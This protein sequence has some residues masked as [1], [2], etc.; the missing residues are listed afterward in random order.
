MKVILKKDIGGLGRKYEIK[1]VSDGYAVNYLVPNKLAE[2]ASKEAVKRAQIAKAATEEELKVQENLKMKQIEALKGV[3][4]VLVKKANEKG[5]LFE[6]IHPE[7][8]VAALKEQARV[9]ISSDSIKM[10]EPIKEIGDHTLLVE[11]GKSRG[12]FTISISAA[13]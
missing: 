9:E 8:I 2:Y 5:H 13:S 12:E 4:I 3:K 11:A 1:E 7:E 10:S 6:K